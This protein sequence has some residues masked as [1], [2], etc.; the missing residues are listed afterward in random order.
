MSIED[1]VRENIRNISLNRM[2]TYNELCN[3]LHI[4]KVN[5]T[6]S[7]NAQWKVIDSFCKRTQIGKGRGTKY[8]ITEIYEFQKDIYDGRC[9]NGS[10]SKHIEVDSILPIV[11]KNKI[12]SLEID[13][14][15]S[16]LDRIVISMYKRELLLELG[17]V[18]EK[19]DTYKKSIAPNQDFINVVKETYPKEL[20]LFNNVSEKDYENK[21]NKIARK[22]IYDFYNNITN[23]RLTKILDRAL[24]RLS[25]ARV[26]TY[27]K[28]YQILFEDGEM[29]NG[30][31]AFSIV[32]EATFETLN[33]WNRKRSVPQGFGYDVKRKSSKNEILYRS[34]HDIPKNL[35]KSFD[36]DVMKF[37]KKDNPKAISFYS[38]YEIVVNKDL[39]G[40]QCTKCETTKDMINDIIYNTLLSTLKDNQEKALNGT[41]AKSYKYFEEERKN[42]CMYGKMLDDTIRI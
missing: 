28:T 39:L 7:K 20:E 33:R 34:V 12:D 21:I 13:N 11:L 18:N 35:L 1:L 32:S 25:K 37:I 31:T 4:K 23:D 24:G 15:C 17:M 40:L 27:K 42:L 41:I 16:N 9:N 6:D 36:E 2:Y 19:Y 5:S 3:I 10:I 30:D 8:I 38:C 22:V 26:L 29:L 14:G